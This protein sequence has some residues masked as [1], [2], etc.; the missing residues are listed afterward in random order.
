VE[1]GM[2]RSFGDSGTEDI[3]HGRPSKKARS[4]LPRH[5]HET[6]SIKM[7]WLDV[8][9]NLEDLRVPPSNHL[10]TLSGELKGYWSIRINKQYRIIF[11][12]AGDAASNVSITDY[13]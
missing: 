1:A 8:A 5:L 13:H 7:D 9:Q 10:E 3:F 6:A 12:W 11:Q 4:T 2:I